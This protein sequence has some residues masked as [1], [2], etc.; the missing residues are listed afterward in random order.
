MPVSRIFLS[1]GHKGC[2]WN[3]CC[4][5]LVGRNSE[6]YFRGDCPSCMMAFPRSSSSERMLQLCSA[7]SSVVVNR[8]RDGCGEGDGVDRIPRMIVIGFSGHSS[9]E[10]KEVMLCCCSSYFGGSRWGVVGSYISR[11][12]A[13]S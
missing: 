3:S 8:K 7:A 4:S 1:L 11:M 5:R 12:V 2:R 10:V 13:L 9:L 6:P